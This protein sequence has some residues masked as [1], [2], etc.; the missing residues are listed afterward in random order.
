M[1]RK[2]L[3]HQ[4][5]SM[6]FAVELSQH[7]MFRRCVR[8]GIPLKRFWK[9]MHDVSVKL[10]DEPPTA[11]VQHGSFQTP[12]LKLTTIANKYNPQQNQKLQERKK[13]L[14]SM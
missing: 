13:A 3:R 8:F 6:R 7:V 1:P 10:T 9:K 4:Y 2:H 12:I 14:N 11:K 5:P